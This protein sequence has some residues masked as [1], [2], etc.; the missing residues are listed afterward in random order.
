MERSKYLIEVISCVRFGLLTLPQLVW[1]KN[2]CDIEINEI[3]DTP[4]VKDMIEDAIR[5]VHKL[6]HYVVCMRSQIHFH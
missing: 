2:S 3:I 6:N 4:E 1:L 5:L